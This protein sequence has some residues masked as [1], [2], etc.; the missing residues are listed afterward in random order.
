VVCRAV[1]EGGESSAAAMVVSEL[2]R[3]EGA[4]WGEVHIRRCSLYLL[5]WYKSTNTE[6]H[7]RVLTCAD[8]C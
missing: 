8:V 5:Y 3:G 2:R 1:F 7:M 4:V 6:V